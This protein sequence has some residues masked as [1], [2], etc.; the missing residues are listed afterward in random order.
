MSASGDTVATVFMDSPALQFVLNYLCSTL[1]QEGGL[2]QTVPGI[3]LVFTVEK[4]IAGIGHHAEV[5][6]VTPTFHLRIEDF[7]GLPVL[8]H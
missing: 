4:V 7:H 5:K 1:Q 2:L 3:G 6:T 8:P